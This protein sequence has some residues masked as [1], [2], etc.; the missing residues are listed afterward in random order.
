MVVSAARAAL[1]MQ[2]LQ[3]DD[4]HFAEFPDEVLGHELDWLALRMGSNTHVKDNAISALSRQDISR[5]SSPLPPINRH[6]WKL[7]GAPVLRKLCLQKPLADQ[8]LNAAARFVAYRTRLASLTDSPSFDSP[9]RDFRGEMVE[10]RDESRRLANVIESTV[11]ILLLKTKINQT[12]KNKRV[13]RDFSA[14]QKT[15]H[16]GKSSVR[17]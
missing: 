3:P 16:Y 15:W 11:K 12:W 8:H 10:V 4:N 7:S 2:R 9:T 14:L 17:L 5:R 1:R 13:L 6:Y